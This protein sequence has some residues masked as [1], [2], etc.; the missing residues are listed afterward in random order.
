MPSRINAAW[1]KAHKMPK[2]PTLE[3]RI[4]WHHAHEQH[5]QCR[6]APEN[7]RKYLEK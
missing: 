3:E 6:K 7:L 1:H 5:C 2:R 4:A